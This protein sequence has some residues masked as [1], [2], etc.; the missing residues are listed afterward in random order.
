MI[1][2][3]R[4]GGGGEIPDFH[5]FLTVDGLSS[6]NQEKVALFL[7]TAGE[8]ISASIMQRKGT[9]SLLFNRCLVSL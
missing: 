5:C 7:M 2:Q 9:D 8:K 1:G 4:G 6:V 3:H